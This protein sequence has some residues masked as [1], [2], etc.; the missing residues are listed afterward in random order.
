MFV[1]DCI[2]VRYLQAAALSRQWMPQHVPGYF[3]L[4][5]STLR[6]LTITLHVT[7]P[8]HQ[9]HTAAYQKQHV[10]AAFRRSQSR[11][12]AIAV[13]MGGEWIKR[14]VVSTFILN[15]EEGNP[16]VALFQRG[17]KVSTYWYVEK[18]DA[19]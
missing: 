19:G 16:R 18:E 15:H 2:S 13:N 5:P 7:S 14:S 9:E 1:M 12:M 11:K 6:H 4:Y 17:D 8:A 10:A 3:R